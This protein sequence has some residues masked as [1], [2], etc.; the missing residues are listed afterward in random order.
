MGDKLGTKETTEALAFI[1]ALANGVGKSADDN[2]WSYSDLL[3]FTSAATTAGPAFDG[4]GKIPAELG[5]LS[6][7][8]KKQLGDYVEK[9]FDIP[10][11]AVEG[12]IE[13]GIKAVLHLGQVVAMVQKH[14]RGPEPQ[15][16]A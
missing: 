16:A 4:V 8:E 3:N 15:S 14:Q 13:E 10:Q 6:D 7:A 11:D 12:I 2:D 5:D 9:N 1:I